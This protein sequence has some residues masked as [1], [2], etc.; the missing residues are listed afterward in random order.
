MTAEQDGLD[1]AKVQIEHEGHRQRHRMCLMKHPEDSPNDHCL[2]YRLAALALDLQGKVAR[3]EAA[4]GAP[5]P[6]GHEVVKRV[7][8]A[9]R[10]AGVVPGAEKAVVSDGG[11]GG[12]PGK[13]EPKPDHAATTSAKSTARPSLS[14][15]E[16]PATRCPQQ[17]PFEALSEPTCTRPEGH[18]GAH[19][20]TSYDGK[21]PLEMMPK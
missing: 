3:V 8:A 9:L 18:V 5:V 20:F 6:P 11:D 17:T 4:L 10:P 15:A 16:R 2:P 19:L 12:L 1:P 21:T 14:S 7:R 13:A